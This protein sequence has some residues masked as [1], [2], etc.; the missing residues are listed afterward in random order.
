MRAIFS[1]SRG[2][3]NTISVCLLLSLCF[4]PAFA[5]DSVRGRPS[6]PHGPLKTRCE[7]CHTTTAWKPIRRQPEFNHDR[8]TGFPLL[9]QHSA[10]SCVSCHTSLVF[11]AAPTQC[12][13]CHADLHRRQF[14]PDCQSCHTVRG[15]KVAVS[16]IKD[17]NNR[18]PLIGAHALATC[19]D[20]HH[21]AASGVY[22]GL[23]TQCVSCHLAD[24]QKASPL[25][26]VA[27][28]LPTT[29]ET[30]HNMNVWSTAKFNHN[31][32]STFALTGAHASLDCAQ[33]HTNGFSQVLPMQCSGCHMA[34]YNATTNP[35]HLTGK[36]PTTC[37][38]CHNTAGWQNATFDHNLSSF[39]LTGAHVTVACAQCHING[40]YVGRP[41]QC[42]GCHLSD[43]KSIRLRLKKYI[44]W[45]G[46]ILIP[47]IIQKLRMNFW[48]WKI[49]P[50]IIKPRVVI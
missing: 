30:C 40:D 22:T 17:H 7:D 14:G 1:R 2:P 48:H 6:N 9:G 33:C 42:V 11:S 39:P 23:N 36:I 26:H 45:V 13:E 32:F 44:S 5:Q 4:A 43:F 27:A 38:N 35:N 37:E 12:S 3:G 31:Q 10:V 28:K 29:C 19:D 21:G 41:T 50:L 16:A 46:G 18:F 15:W 25:N 34:D 49:L 24:Y 47:M 20:C 8:Q